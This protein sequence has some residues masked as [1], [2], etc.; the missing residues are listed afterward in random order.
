MGNTNP[1]ENKR[2]DKQ[3]ITKLLK[4]YKLEVFMILSKNSQIKNLI[5]KLDTEIEKHIKKEIK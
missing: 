3:M 4:T 1:T 2:V 5:K